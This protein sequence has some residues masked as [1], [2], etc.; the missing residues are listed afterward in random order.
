MADEKNEGGQ[1]QVHQQ[2][3]QREQKQSTRTQGTG[4]RSE[5]EKRQ[6]QMSNP[7]DAMRQSTNQQR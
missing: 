2:P 3:G 7:D 5:R 4:E 1:K 6:D